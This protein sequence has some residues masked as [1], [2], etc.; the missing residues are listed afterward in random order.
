[1]HGAGAVSSSTTELLRI[2]G[3]SLLRL[4]GGAA[5]PDPD[6]P[7][8][9]TMTEIV[10]L[11]RSVTP[12]QWRGMARLEREVRELRAQ[13]APAYGQYLRT[14]ELAEA[15]SLLNRIAGVA[16]GAGIEQSSEWG[17]GAYDR[18]VDMFDQVDFSRCRR[19]AM[20]G[21]GPLPVT[22]LHIS[23]RTEVPEILALDI[24][25]EAL[26]LAERLVERLGLARIRVQSANG[27]AFDF[28]GTDVIYVANLVSPKASVLRRIAGTAA[29]GAQVIL[30]NPYA[31]G[32]LLAED[33]TEDLDAGLSVTGEGA[34]NMR[35]LS[36]HVFLRRSG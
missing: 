16:G 17:R 6:S 18:V 28:S 2:L 34:G 11:I 26:A 5:N 31:A 3:E 15:A 33:G 4:E 35:F 9:R 32:H 8:A 22:A 36:R 21:C 14:L 30:R 10:E 25:A 7:W 1:M 27:S 24:D 12:E 20:V 29:P 19:F 23:D 13:L